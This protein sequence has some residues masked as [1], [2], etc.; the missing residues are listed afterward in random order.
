[1]NYP[2]PHAP[3]CP[4]YDIAESMGAPNLKWCEENLC[5]WISEPS[6]TWSNLGYLTA[7][8]LTF[9]WAMK[10]N[11]SHE[12]KQFGPIIFFMGSMSFLYHLSNFYLSQIFDFIGM[13]TFTGWIIGMNLI[14][15]SLIKRKNLIWFNLGIVMIETLILHVMYLN[16]IKFQVIILIN[17]F[18]IVTTEFLARRKVT[19]SYRNY[20][21]GLFF[22]ILAFSFSILDAKRIWCIPQNH[23]W[24]SQGHA[25]WHWAAAI[26][27]L[28]I[29]FH[30][31]QP[32]LKLK[33]D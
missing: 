11:E 9:Y 32:N 10:K 24:F 2:N 13:Y 33:K 6:N 18:L 27:M 17:A 14:R 31:A 4:W 23:G 29:Y 5:Q 3:S 26:A 19:I 25:L 16:G 7:G 22:L 20:Y 30:Y 28:F 21:L 8:I 15:L 12:L 1:M